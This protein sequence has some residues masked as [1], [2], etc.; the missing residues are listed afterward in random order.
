[1]YVYFCHTKKYSQKNLK[2]C[3][4]LPNSEN[5]LKFQ[6]KRKTSFFDKKICPRRG[7]L[8]LVQKMDKNEK[9]FFFSISDQL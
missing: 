5:G 2:N 3:P 9:K 1:M 8:F 6:K 4:K 7:R